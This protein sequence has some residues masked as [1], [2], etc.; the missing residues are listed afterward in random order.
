MA[1]RKKTGKTKRKVSNRVAEYRMALGLSQ[2][3]LAARCAPGLSAKTIARVET[4]NKS[5]ASI[6]YHRIL[7]A[8]NNARREQGQSALQMEAVFPN[9]I[10]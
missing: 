8:L 5:F 9:G 2:T 4:E 7:N 6:T 3:Q 10:E 1:T